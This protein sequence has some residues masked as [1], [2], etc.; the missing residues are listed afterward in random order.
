MI[1]L[2]IIIFIIGYA[3]IAVEHNIKINKAAIALTLSVTLWTIYIMGGGVSII[4]IM[5]T[6]SFKSFLLENHSLKSH[7]IEHQIIS[8]I[9][10]KQI[11]EHIGDVAEILF[12]LLGAMTIVELIDING[13]FIVITEKITTRDKKKLLWIIGILTFLMSAL[14]DN[15]TTSIIMIMLLKK[16]VG[17]YKERWLY[18]GIIIIAANSGGAW[19]PIGDV[20][21]IMLWVKGNLETTSLITSLFIPS[22][23]SLI[24]P[25]LIIERFLKNEITPVYKIKEQS[26]DYELPSKKARTFILIMGIGCL[27]SVPIFKTITHLPPFMGILLGLGIMWIITELMRARNSEL[28]SNIHTVVQALKK[29]DVATILFFL[30]I[31]MS[32][33]VLQVSGILEQSA[34][35]LE[36]GIGN[37]YAINIILGLLSSIVDNVPLVAAAIG[38]YPL[39]D[40][41][42]A[43]PEIARY[44]ASGGVFWEFLSYCAGTGGSILIIGSAAGVITMGLEKINFI[45]YLKNISLPALIGYISG[46]LVLMFEYWIINGTL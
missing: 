18:A 40:P 20:T 26:G 39:A 9:T 42:T 25:M 35:L 22:L 33:A 11:I 24:I 43:A 45:W 8:F 14:L 32:V 13:G 44:F 21:T 7:S 6:E 4:P 1:T 46:A 23:V 37:I 28:K 19:S 5:E 36:D 16:I 29:N 34:K 31:L 27:V 30:G 41:L 12:F 17:N 15:L 3:A 2:L 38:M 10:N